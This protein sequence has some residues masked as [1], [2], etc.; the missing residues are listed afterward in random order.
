MDQL[1]PQY[2]ANQFNRMSV[3]LMC[4]F[5]SVACCLLRY[6]AY[7]LLH[8]IK[9]QLKKVGQLRNSLTVSPEALVYF[10]N[11]GEVTFDD[12]FWVLKVSKVSVTKV[13]CYGRSNVYLLV[14]PEFWCDFVTSCNLVPS[15]FVAILNGSFQ[16]HRSY[17][18]ECLHQINNNLMLNNTQD[19]ATK[20]SNCAFPCI[21]WNLGLSLDIICFL[22][23]V[24]LL[25][26]VKYVCS[27]SDF[28]ES[29]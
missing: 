3:T 18:L 14:T 10:K 22:M 27:S 11:F 7:K 28:F 4:V 21:I 16:R 15:I 25:L 12:I 19:K 1:S 29:D 8:T 23:Y 2:L 24:V 13:D 6:S 20:R 17:P 5:E 26:E 9:N